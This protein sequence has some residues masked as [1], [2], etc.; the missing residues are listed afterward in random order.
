MYISLCILSPNFLSI[1]KWPFLNCFFYPVFAQLAKVL[2]WAQKSEK[3]FQKLV[4]TLE[5]IILSDTSSSSHFI[6][7]LQEAAS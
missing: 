1:Q 7:A 2:F 6:I 4:V 5:A 3:G